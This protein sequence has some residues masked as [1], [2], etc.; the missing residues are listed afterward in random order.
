MV[1]QNRRYANRVAN[2]IDSR[3]VEVVARDLT[4]ATLTA[5]ELALDV[6]P[7]TRSPIARPVRVWIHY[8]AQ[9]VQVDA[10]AVAWTTRAVAV[11][12]RV[13]D[14]VHRAWVWAGAVIDPN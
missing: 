7:L 1:G 9:A 10:E 5:A 13:G 4:P 12:W 2:D 14:Q 11:R 8:G 3:I 6:E